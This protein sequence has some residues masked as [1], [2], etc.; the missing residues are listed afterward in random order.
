[1]ASLLV[2]HGLH[3]LDLET[4]V[5]E[6]LDKTR[7]RLRAQD[8]SAELVSIQD[9]VVRLR[10]RTNGHGCGSAQALKEM[11]EEAVYQA[12]PDVTA[13]IIEGADEKQAFVPL[14]M[15]QGNAP[16]HQISTGLSF[17]R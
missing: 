11:V 13:L 8:A 14:A 5:T 7:L 17:H 15:L 10:L 2:L 1:M 16:V 6:A 12:A 3:P 9:G 4:R